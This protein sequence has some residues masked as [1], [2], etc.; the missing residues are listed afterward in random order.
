MERG[1]RQ[2]CVISPLLFNL[3]SDFMIKEKNGN[4]E[5]I[6][7]SG[8]HVTDLRYADDAV[9]MADKRSKMQNMIDK[10][11]MSRVWQGN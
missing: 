5:E 11:I 4:V 3:Y 6:K 2:G 8:K 7:F 9:L 1:V 10:R